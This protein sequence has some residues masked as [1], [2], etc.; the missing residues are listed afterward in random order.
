VI[1]WAAWF[2]LAYWLL[3]V[4]TVV[5]ATIPGLVRRPRLSTWNLERVTES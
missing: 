3:S 1:P 5:R 4:L 2:P